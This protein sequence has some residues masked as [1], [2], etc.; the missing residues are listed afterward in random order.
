MSEFQEAVSMIKADV[1]SILDDH[2]Q[3]INSFN[4]NLNVFQQHFNLRNSSAK[5][6]M[7]TFLNKLKK[8]M[9]DLDELINASML[10]ILTE[11]VGYLQDESRYKHREMEEVVDV[12]ED[13]CTEMAETNEEY[14]VL[15]NH[16]KRHIRLCPDNSAKPLMT[17]LLTI[18]SQLT[19]N[20][21]KVL[22]EGVQC[23]INQYF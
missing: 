21:L 22:S 10:G 19:K 13:I 16:T 7:E 8:K 9:E 11:E 12:L 6:R 5:E 15:I 18:I 17:L 2:R 20:W 14:F 3:L 4:D 1:Q 23:T